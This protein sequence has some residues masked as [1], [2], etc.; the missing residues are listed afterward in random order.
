MSVGIYLPNM[1]M[2]KDGEMLCVNIYPD[3]KVCINLDLEC[4]RI[5]TAVPVQKHGRLI[6]KHAVY[7]LIWSFPNVDRQLPVEFMKALYELTTIIDAEEG[8][9]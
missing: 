3:G 7:K 4:K 8:K 5:A 6:E 1:E 2:P 9:A